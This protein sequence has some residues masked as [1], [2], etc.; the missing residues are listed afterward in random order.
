MNVFFINDSTSNHNWGDRAAAI[1]LK[2]MISER[3]GTITGTIT[4]D[5]LKR[6]RFAGNH[7]ETGED[8]GLDVV[9]RMLKLFIPPIVLKVREKIINRLSPSM[10][11][12]DDIVPRK[13]EEFDRHVE[14]VLCSHTR[15]SALLKAI[16]R[17]DVVIIHGGGCMTGITRIARA[18]L[19]L[20]YL[21]KKHFGKPVAIVNHTADF[22]HPDLLR[23]AQK[24]YPLY[25]DVVYRDA[26]SEEQ[27][28]TLWHG[29]HAADSAFLFTPAPLRQWLPVAQRD[30]YFDVWPDTACFN[31]AEPYICIGGSSIFSYDSTPHHLIRGFSELISHLRSLYAGQIVL[32]VS[33]II[34]QRI[35]RPL[36]NELN[37]PLVGL[38]IPVQQAVDI[39]GNAQ[40]YIGGRWHPGIFA[41]RGGA[42]VIPFSSKTFKMQSLVQMAGLSQD[43][44]DALKVDEQKETIGR[45]L[46]ECLEQGEALRSK[47]RGWAAEQSENC[48]E[49]VAVLRGRFQGQALP[50]PPCSSCG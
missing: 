41:L 26:I 42:P 38:T 22:R 4:E 19:F 44:F 32:T 50:D 37:L 5:E 6:S 35:F 43:T 18:E 2:N 40:A 39:V 14:M 12:A 49:N 1:A 48:W 13:W 3:G 24:V 33:D 10:A 11:D 15:H 29:R 25:E 31:P 34:D 30:T 23:M 28:R 27:Y 21:I 20:S 9:K 8:S 7:A 45:S 46:M 17:S 47:L 16:E 36:A